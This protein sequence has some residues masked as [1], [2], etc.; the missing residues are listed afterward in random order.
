MEKQEKYNNLKAVSQSQLKALLKHPQEYIS[1]LKRDNKWK[2]YLALGSYFDMLLTEPE[3]I[4]NTFKVIEKVPGPKPLAAAEIQRKDPDRSLL[5]II[6]EVGFRTN[7]EDDKERL[8]KYKEETAEFQ[9]AY[10]KGLVPI[11]ITDVMLANRMAN[12]VKES[13]YGTIFTNPNSTPQLETRFQEALTSTYKTVDGNEY[14]LKGLLDVMLIDHETKQIKIVDLKTYTNKGYDTFNYNGI[15]RRMRYDFQLAF[16]KQL[17]EDNW[18]SYTVTACTLMMVNTDGK[19]PV[20]CI[21]LSDS[22]LLIGREG[23]VYGESNIEGWT[24]ALER[25]EWHEA[26]NVWDYPAEFKGGSR[27]IS[28]AWA[29]QVVPMFTASIIPS[30]VR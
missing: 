27:T 17:V 29:R 14:T 4:N 22:D 24:Q 23:G 16:Y 10:K 19:Y 20:A 28:S 5:S 30:M 13:K 18:P 15:I 6:N 11:S 9:K 3:E 7:I 1:Q 8:K 12:E 21:T 25:L 26:K 2:N